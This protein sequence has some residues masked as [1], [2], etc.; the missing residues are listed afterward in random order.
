MIIGGIRSDSFNST[1]FVASALYMQDDITWCVSRSKEISRWKNFYYVPQDFETYALGFFTFFTVIINAYLFTTFEEKPLDLVLCS[2]Y[3]V[4]NLIGNAVQ[5]NPKLWLSRFHYGHFLIY[6]FWLT[7]IFNGYLITYMSIILYE[8][9]ISTLEGIA[10]NRFHLCGDSGVLNHL[11]VQNMVKWHMNTNNFF[12]FFFSKKMVIFI[13]LFFSYLQ[14]HNEQMEKFEII[15]DIDRCL[16]RLKFDDK[17]AVATSRFHVKTT[18]HEKIDCFD[19]SQN[20]HNY[21]NTFMIR[22]DFPKKKLFNDVLKH[23]VSSGLVPKWKKDLQFYR[24]TETTTSVKSIR[25]GIMVRQGIMFFSVSI[26]TFI[27]EII[28]HR[29]A[30][31]NNASFFW[32]FLDK[33]IYGQ[34][35]F[36][37]L[38][39]NWEEKIFFSTGVDDVYD[40]PF[41]VRFYN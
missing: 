39:K 6:P 41:I 11:I 35:C 1:E 37:L 3:T 24:E 9:Q 21:L 30:H 40:E 27:V 36:F 16:D 10:Q 5:Y 18:P 4:A 20:I 7:Q 15:D 23:V 22:S 12:I 33:V 17:L 14:F 8:K 31:S 38:Q 19:Q 25:N 2:I 13:F 32:K 28:I 29:K 26:S 34:R